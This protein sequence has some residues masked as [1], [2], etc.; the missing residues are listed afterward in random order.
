MRAFLLLA[1][2]ILSL[3]V[4]SSVARAD[5]V[6]V[7]IGRI[8]PSLH[9]RLGRDDSVDI[10]VAY[11]S[12]RPLR[13]QARAYLDGVSADVGQKM[14]ASPLYP[15]GSGVAH[16]W[17]AYYKTAEVDEIRVTVYDDGW[18]EISV[19]SLPGYLRW[20]EASPASR[21]KP[22]WVRQ[23]REQLS[24]RI[25]EQMRVGDVGDYAF[26]GI[27]IGLALMAAFPGYLALQYLTLRGFSGAWRMLAALPALLMVPVVA[28]TVTALMAGSNLWPIVLI[29]TAPV[30]FAYLAALYGLRWLIRP[31]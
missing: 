25:A 27:F 29:F 17:V 13:I 21:D 4:P 19:H 14:N 24:N 31:A 22:A 2:F 5:A 15:A 3:C 18:R 20:D 11:R 7:K 28:F 23:L 16:A 12:D 8:S 9:A 10:E 26:I 1:T 6:E 30:A